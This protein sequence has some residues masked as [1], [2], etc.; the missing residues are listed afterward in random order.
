MNFD[1]IFRM[2]TLWY[3]EHLGGDLDLWRQWPVALAEVCA[4]QVHLVIIIR[5]HSPY[6]VRTDAA[7]Y[8]YRP[9]SVVCRL[10]CL[11]VG[12]SV[13]VLS[14]SKTAKPIYD[15]SQKRVPP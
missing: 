14:P 10:V 12:L 15:V 6:Y 7:A 5:P 13:T 1:D 8:C 4:L 9:I 11:S 3:K 2:V